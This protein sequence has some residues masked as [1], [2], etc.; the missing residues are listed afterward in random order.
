MTI[1]LLSATEHALLM[2]MFE[3]NPNLTFQNKGYDTL[4]LHNLPPDDQHKLLVINSLLRKCIGGFSSFSHFKV[5][6]A[7]IPQVR[8]Q[9]NYNHD[10]GGI[11]F[12]GVGYLLIDEL[13]N[14]FVAPSNS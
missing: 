11:P 9:Y 10:N 13:L 3:D 4:N 5:N 8:F 14:G 7:G 6:A 12:V 1:T 2:K